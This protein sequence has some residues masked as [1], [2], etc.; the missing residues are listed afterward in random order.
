[1]KRAFL[2][3][4]LAFAPIATAASDLFGIYLVT[5]AEDPGARKLKLVWPGG[6][7]EFVYLDS[8]P[9]LE[10]SAIAA[11]DVET[12]PG[13][14]SQIR[15]V[16]TAEGARKLSEL[17]SRNVGR[18]LGIV[19]DG[20]L[21]SAPFV[22]GSLSKDLVV[23]GNFSSSEASALAKKLGPPSASI[24]PSQRLAAVRRPYGHRPARSRRN[25]DVAERHGN[26][27]PVPD[28]QI[29]DRHVDL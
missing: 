24:R 9:L 28:A 20:Q 16:L 15:L 11:A 19:V 3:A 6:A 29:L 26:G 13:G 22:S 14:G 21:R 18:R 4:I 10:A 1:M 12:G 2:A 8:A 5:T 27:R 25:L 23:G 7:V 17:T